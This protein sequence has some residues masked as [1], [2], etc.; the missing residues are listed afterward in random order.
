ME[1]ETPPVLAAYRRDG[2]DY[3]WCEYCFVW[4]MHGPG[5]GHRVAHCRDPRSP[6]KRAGYILD[7]RGNM[8]TAIARDH[9]QVPPDLPALTTAHLKLWHA[10]YYGQDKFGTRV[11]RPVNAWQLLRL[12]ELNR[13]ADTIQGSHAL[14]RQTFLTWQLQ[15]TPAVKVRR[16]RQRSPSFTH[17]AERPFLY[18]AEELAALVVPDDAEAALTWFHRNAV[19]APGMVLPLWL[20]WQSYLGWT[21]QEGEAYRLS[22]AEWLHQLTHGTPLTTARRPDS[23]ERVF[24][25]YALREGG[26]AEA[27]GSVS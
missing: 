4:H 11:Q 24:L 26:L 17:T 12:F 23:P 1:E 5:H 15:R 20:A 25:D 16:H 27:A 9:G 2:D 8:T 22:R 19:A 18:S 14:A 6:Y 7:C 13:L 3:V 21:S 10:V